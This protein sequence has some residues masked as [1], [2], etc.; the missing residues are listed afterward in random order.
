MTGHV[1]PNEFRAPLWVRRMTSR[2]LDLVKDR[3][4]RRRH[5]EPAPDDEI[6]EVGRDSFPASDPP[7]WTLGIDR[8]DR[9]D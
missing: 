5:D 3:R 1:E 9:K 4:A 7:A 6:D 2:L 8:R